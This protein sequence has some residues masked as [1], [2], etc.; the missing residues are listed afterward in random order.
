MCAARA[1]TTTEP[2]ADRTRAERASICSI[3]VPADGTCA[4][5]SS[6]GRLRYVP[7]LW[8]ALGQATAC[9]CIHVGCEI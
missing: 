8:A 7:D 3:I 5:T 1:S 2:G 9:L 6:E 4:A